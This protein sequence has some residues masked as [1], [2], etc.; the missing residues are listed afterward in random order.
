[1]N[2]L[3]WKNP[4]VIT[5]FLLRARRGGFFTTVVLYIMFLVM[6]YGA[7]L[8]YVSL[9]PQNV[10]N[11]SK[12]FFLILYIGQ[13][14]LS[15]ILML[16]GGS[17]AIKNEVMNKTL[18]F[19]RIAAVSPWDILIGK[20]LGVPT[21]AYLLAIT[22]FPMG[23]FCIINGV[24]GVGFLEL[25]LLWVQLLT[26]LF[27]LGAFSIQNTL[28]PGSTARATG[29][30]HGFGVLMGVLT[31]AVFQTYIGGDSTSFL[32][33]PLRNALASLLTPLHSIAGI[34]VDNPWEA[35]FYWFSIGIPCL[36]LS[37]IAHLLIAWFCL[38]IMARRLTTVEN[39]PQGKSLVYLFI[40]VGDLLLAGVLQSTNRSGP[41]G[42]AAIPL[43]IQV[44]VFFIIHLILTAILLV[45]VTPKRE[46][47]WSWVWR[48]RGLKPT[49]HDALWHDR[50]LNTLPLIISVFSGALSL[51]LLIVTSGQA[52]DWQ[53][54]IL[55]GLAV[56][57]MI[58]CW[59]VL[60]QWS[61]LA[62]GKYGT[63]L[64]MI[65]AV[66][67]LFSPVM[68]GFILWG[69]SNGA[70]PLA[71]PILHLTPVLEIGNWFGDDKS[72]HPA[73][74]LVTGWPITVAYF[75]LG[76]LMLYLL[77]ARLDK[78]IERVKQTKAGMGV[79]TQGLVSA[80]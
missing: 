31:L 35:K 13:C 54:L 12:V 32:K 30:S 56:V 21:L 72:Q 16:A 65:L 51:T 43:R 3:P 6:G 76:F 29:A 8:Y 11:P 64:F 74:A 4:L 18:D 19:Q 20:L 38:S 27:L 80:G 70:H 28:Q 24:P 55:S 71:I 60:F 44:G 69:I 42:A 77:H 26:F 66:M 62:A 17:G 41:L 58:F 39:T 36:I 7:W 10:K 15:G 59:G 78:M 67:A 46:L 75:V 34:F 22:A 68:L 23:V 57:A 53:A 79:D 73:L 5:S 45:A 25:V 47:L 9:Y 2:L 1:M 14:I 40:I 50:C 48:F 52:V 61:V 33:N 49:W 63:S 37:P